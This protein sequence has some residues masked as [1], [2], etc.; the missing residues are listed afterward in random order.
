M[1]SGIRCVAPDLHFFA[2]LFFDFDDQTP[3]KLGD[4]TRA[5]YGLVVEVAVTDEDVVD[6]AGYVSHDVSRQR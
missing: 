6:E 4:Q 1:A 5:V 2:K 3:V